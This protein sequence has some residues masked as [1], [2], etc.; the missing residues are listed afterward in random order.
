[1][2]A[3]GGRGQRQAPRSRVAAALL[4]LEP[5]LAASGHDD[6]FTG[7]TDLGPTAALAREVSPDRHAAP[8]HVH[9]QCCPLRQRS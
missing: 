4:I 5:R 7:V 8:A 3:G 2:N 1:M 6:A 9:R